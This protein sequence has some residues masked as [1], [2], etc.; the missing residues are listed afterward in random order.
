[1]SCQYTDA[2]PP[3]CRC[4]SSFYSNGVDLVL[5][6]AYPMV[7]CGCFYYMD[8]ESCNSNWNLSFYSFLHCFYHSRQCTVWDEWEDIVSRVEATLCPVGAITPTGIWKNKW[9]WFEIIKFL[10]FVWPTKIR[11]GRAVKFKSI[12]PLA[13]DQ[14]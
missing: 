12:Q 14:V 6:A 5:T 13:E 7:C 1:M 3:K 10:Y 8:Q 11:I 4:A 2:R 9:T